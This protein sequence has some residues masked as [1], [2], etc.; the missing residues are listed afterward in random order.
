[1]SMWDAKVALCFPLLSDVFEKIEPDPPRVCI[2]PLGELRAG[3][4][5]RRPGE[6]IERCVFKAR[7]S[8][9]ER[10]SDQRGRVW[11]DK[12][13]PVENGICDTDR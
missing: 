13:R 7:C 2:W 10:D 9:K 4:H 8:H 6:L 11:L 5:G 3:E 1:M 12:Q